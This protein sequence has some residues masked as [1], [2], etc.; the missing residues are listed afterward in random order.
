M[1]TEVRA[2]LSFDT[3]NDALAHIIEIDMAVGTIE[4]TRALYDYTRNVLK[5]EGALDD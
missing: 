4:F 2:T 3:D 5:T 1:H